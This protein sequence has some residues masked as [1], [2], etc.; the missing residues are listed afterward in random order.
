MGKYILSGTAIGLVAGLNIPWR[1]GMCC[2]TCVAHA[3]HWEPRSS[4]PTAHRTV[5]IVCFFFHFLSTSSPLPPHPV[6]VPLLL[7]GP[8]RSGG[9]LRPA[10]V[11]SHQR[12]REG[13]GSSPKQSKPSVGATVAG[14][15]V[16][17]LSGQD[18]TLRPSTFMGGLCVCWAVHRALSGGS[19]G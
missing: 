2:G 1:S 11:H 16:K 6:V 8:A 4:N 15:P 17:V 13:E 7:G 5:E 3:K 9:E 18:A 10:A 12:G 19:R 14:Q